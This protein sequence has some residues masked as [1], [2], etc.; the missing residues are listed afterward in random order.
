MWKNY[1]ST[2]S[3]HNFSEQVRCHQGAT[4]LRSCLNTYLPKTLM[5]NLP[6]SIEALEG[7]PEVSPMSL[8]IP[9]HIQAGMAT[10]IVV[11]A[12]AVVEGGRVCRRT[13]RDGGRTYVCRVCERRF[14]RAYLLLVHE[15]TH[16]PLTCPVCG[17]TFRR[18]EHMRIHREMHGGNKRPT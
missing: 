11:G 10:G 13:R 2:T 1:C 16:T 9:V 17:R 15:R 7:T 18:A 14:P 12:I 3:P 4:C 6:V 5:K 8:M